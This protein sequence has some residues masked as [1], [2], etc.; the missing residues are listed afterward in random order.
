VVFLYNNLLPTRIAGGLLF[1]TL[2]ELNWLKPIKKA[3][4]Y[5]FSQALDLPILFGGSV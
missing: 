2:R 4:I 1:R 5:N 3:E